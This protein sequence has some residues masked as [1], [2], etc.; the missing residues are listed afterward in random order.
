MP[1]PAIGYRLRPDARTRFVTAEF[2][3]RDRDQRAGRPRRRADRAQ[4]GRTSAASS[5]SAIRSSCRCRSISSRRSASCSRQRLNRGR[6]PDPLPRHQRRRAG[7]R[8]G[9]GAAVLS[10]RGA[11]L[12]A[13]PRDRDDVRRQRRGGG[14]DVRAA[15][16]RRGPLADDALGLVRSTRLRRLVRRSMVLQVAAAAARV[17]D[18]PVSRAA[19]RRRSRRSSPTPSSPAPRIAEGLRIARDCVQAIAAEAAASGARTMVMLMPARFQVDDA[20]YGRLKEAVEGAGGTLV[21]DAATARFDEALAPLRAAAVRR[22]A[23]AA[24]RAAGAG[25]LLPADGAPDAA[26]PRDRGR[27]RSRRSSARQGL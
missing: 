26:R 1:D 13:G 6:R 27:A 23:A 19:A 3:T 7:L 17:G 4:A 14:G 10:P 22:A 8:P 21:R 9:R 24:R 15:P 11:R 5:C 18:R 20:D 2:D 25:R 12:P 16:A